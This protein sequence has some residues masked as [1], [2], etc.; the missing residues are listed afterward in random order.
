MRYLLSLLAVL[1][2]VVQAPYF[3]ERFAER[4]G[5]EIYDGRLEQLS[6]LRA[7]G[8]AAAI[9]IGLALLAHEYAHH[10]AKQS[11]FVRP[12]GALFGFALVGSAVLAGMLAPAGQGLEACLIALLTDA[13]V[14]GAVLAWVGRTLGG[15]QQQ[16]TAGPDKPKVAKP[17]AAGLPPAGQ[18]EP[19]P[20]PDAS[21][22]LWTC[23][24]CGAEFASRQG[25]AGHAK[26]H[27]E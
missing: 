10:A 25:L 22:R 24:K 5:I 14:A 21:V 13:I 2:V 1:G 16:Q 15:K 4:L 6:A 17:K 11:A 18:E 7:G 26:V 23:K 19:Q 27:R 9:S 12:L 3:L 8:L 20:S